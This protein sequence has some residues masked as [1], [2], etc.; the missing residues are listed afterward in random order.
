MLPSS[1]TLVSNSST[2]HNNPNFTQTVRMWVKHGKTI[3]IMCKEFRQESC[4]RAQLCAFGYVLSRTCTHKHVQLQSLFSVPLGPS[5]SSA[6]AQTAISDTPERGTG[7]VGVIPPS[8]VIAVL[9]A[10]LPPWQC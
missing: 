2:V 3:V 1:M 5:A 6:W 7:L 10:S 8:A 9:Q 4:H